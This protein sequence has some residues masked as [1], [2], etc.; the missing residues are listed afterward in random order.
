MTYR[1]SRH[2]VE[3]LIHCYERDFGVHLS[4][5]DADRMLVLF[6]ELSELFYKYDP[7]EEQEEDDSPFSLFPRLSGK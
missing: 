7:E 1:N 4:F 3:D 5:E 2:E 6:D